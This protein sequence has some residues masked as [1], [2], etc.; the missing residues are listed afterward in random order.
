[1]RIGISTD[2]HTNR[3]SRFIIITEG[4]KR[5]TPERRKD[6]YAPEDVYF[7]LILRIGLIFLFSLTMLMI[8]S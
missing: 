2:Q 5:Q 4:L 1:M 7:F 8:I 6:L 3:E